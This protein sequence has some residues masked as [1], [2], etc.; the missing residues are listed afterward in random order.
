ML[1]VVVPVLVKDG[2]KA[3]FLKT[4]ETLIEKSRNEKGCIEYLLVDTG[5]DNE[6]YFI[7][8]W[9]T[10]EDLQVHAKASHSVE[11]QSLLNPL[12]QQDFPVEIYE[13]ELPNTMLSRR[14][15]RSYRD[16]AVSD[17]AIERILRAA[18]YAPSAGN[19]QAWEFLVVKNRQK[20][21]ELSK[22]SPY[23]SSLTK[24]NVAIVVLGKTDK[25]YPQYLEQDL[26]AAS[27]NIL[28]QVVEEGLGAVWLGVAP[29][30]DRM[31]FVKKLFN[32]DGITLP[33]CIIPLG[34][35][36]VQ[37]KPNKPDNR[38]IPSKIITI[39]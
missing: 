22:V 36:A 15:V 39:N 30:V 6:L 1:R 2:K 4:A 26:G 28:L 35:P 18:M 24:A 38:Y 17:K 11:Y 32:L 34:H 10:H 3:E 23:A 20:L 37:I 21:D 9:E 25:K 29:E 16:Q 5:K 31:N 8:K 19:Q 13:T 14:S 7:E 27:Q 33:F 12:K